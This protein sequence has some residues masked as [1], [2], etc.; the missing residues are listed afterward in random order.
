MGGR[1]GEGALGGGDAG[2][3]DAG[4]GA[5]ARGG[6]GAEPGDPGEGA[7][8]VRVEGGGVRPVPMGRREVSARQEIRDPEGLGEVSKT[9]TLG[10]E[11]GE[12]CAEGEM[13][14]GGRTCWER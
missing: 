1:A 7:W 13:G 5:E 6:L 4:G 12:P 14:T 8:A 3:G 10:E 9:A 11:G 2:G